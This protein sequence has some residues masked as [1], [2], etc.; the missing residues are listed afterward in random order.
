[1]PVFWHN[2]AGLPFLA[3][4]ARPLLVA[5]TLHPLAELALGAARRKAD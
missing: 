3:D 4:K 5:D 1:M 2:R